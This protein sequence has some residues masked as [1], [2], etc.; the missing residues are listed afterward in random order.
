MTRAAQTLPASRCCIEL[1][2]EVAKVLETPT[3]PL[4]E[5]AHQNMEL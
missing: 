5:L 3:A 4:A 2:A 1:Q